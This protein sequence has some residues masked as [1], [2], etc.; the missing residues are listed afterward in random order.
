MNSDTCI[1]EYKRTPSF[2]CVGMP[3]GYSICVFTNGDVVRLDYTIGDEKPNGESILATLPEL[4]KT[5]QSIVSRYSE[6]LKSIPSDL[7]NGTLDGSHECF[8]FGIKRINAWT[9]QRTNLEETKH[10]NLS[11]YNVYKNNME[12]ENLVLD[13]YDEIA[14]EINKHNVGIRMETL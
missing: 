6:E 12:Y 4:S 13:I 1:F 14:T 10:S 11:Y 2:G 8:Q 9:I 7:N 3:G 5:I